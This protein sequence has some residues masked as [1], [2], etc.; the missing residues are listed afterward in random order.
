MDLGTFLMKTQLQLQSLRL[1][2][3]IYLPL[4]AS[5]ELTFISMVG[6]THPQIYTALALEIWSLP[7]RSLNTPLP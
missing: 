3:T 6:R 2:G 4:R 7:G 5:S 1:W